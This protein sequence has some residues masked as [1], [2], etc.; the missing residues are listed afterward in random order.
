[1]GLVASCYL[2]FYVLAALYIICVKSNPYKNAESGAS[3]IKRDL[4][5]WKKKKQD[6]LGWILNELAD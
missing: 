2:G 6:D 5:G 3:V 4:K 1:M